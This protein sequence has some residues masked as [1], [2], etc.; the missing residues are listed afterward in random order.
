M[1][2]FASRRWKHLI[3]AA[4]LSAL[5]AAGGC[6]RSEWPLW[7]AYKARF[8]DGQGRV[9]DPRGDGRST[10]E[11]QSY[12]LF[13]ALVDNDRAEFDRVL[14]WTQ[15]NLA[16]GDLGTHLC[17]SKWGK[18][19]D[20]TS[21]VL[22]ADSASGADVWL[23]YTL[24]E[25]G[26]LWNAADYTAM[27]RG[28][29]ALIAKGEVADLPGFGPMLLPGSQGYVHDRGWT[30]HPGDLPLFLFERL[31][32]VDPAGPW[33]AIAQNIPRVVEGST[34][35]GFAMDWIEFVPGD[36]FYAAAQNPEETSSSRDSGGNYDAIRVYLWAGMLDANSLQRQML[37]AVD[38]MSGYL[39]GHNFPPE[40]VDRSG[41]PL[42]NDGPVGFSAALL[43]YL[44]ASGE[45]KMTA[46]QI[47][48]MNAERN[49]ATGMYGR[50][51]A[52]DDQNLALFGTGFLDDR[53]EFG[54]AGELN[55]EWNR[56]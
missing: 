38:G 22:D 49:A 33:H 30:L 51:S 8:I 40:R 52:Y 32:Q 55:V 11:G 16:A 5:S 20:G 44:R 53:F 15:T 6:N 1:G 36:G 7:N 24:L 37:H 19:P 35:H 48:R 41:I 39:G 42:G 47:V 17:A 23:A 46:R 21:R 4:A 54:Q 3:F 31:A 26:R 45:S 29:L 9:F 25:A 2:V 14:A 43:P 12:A 56:A 34:R 27:A 18:A 50:D 13:F 10:S 28:Q